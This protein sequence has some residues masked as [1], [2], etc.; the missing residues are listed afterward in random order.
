MYLLEPPIGVLYVDGAGRPITKE[1]E[2]IW[3]IVKADNNMES[4]VTLT[5]EGCLGSA[6]LWRTFTVMLTRN[7]FLS[8][9]TVGRGCKRAQSNRRNRHCDHE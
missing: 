6:L 3:E 7:C 1:K 8:I 9:A 2:K 4:K 5:V